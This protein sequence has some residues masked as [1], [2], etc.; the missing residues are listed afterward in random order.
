MRFP[1]KDARV[2]LAS[3]AVT[4][5]TTPLTIGVSPEVGVMDVL[6]VPLPDGRYCGLVVFAPAT[7]ERGGEAEDAVSGPCLCFW[8]SKAHAQRSLAPRGK[9]FAVLN[10]RVR[11]VWLADISAAKAAGFLK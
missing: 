8:A 3:P 11:K 4:P 9:G 5:A 1:S 7:Y 10:R 6:P 2:A